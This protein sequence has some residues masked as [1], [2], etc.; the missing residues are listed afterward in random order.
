MA[1]VKK[2]IEEFVERIRSA[3]G[4]N[5][6]SVVLYGSAAREDFNEQY[7]DVNLLCLLKRVDSPALAQIAPVVQWWSG[8]LGRRPPLVITT[9]E[10]RN[11]AD[12]FAI[13][14]LDIKEAHRILHGPNVISDVDVPMNLHRVQLEHELRT[15]LLRLRQ[16]LL[17][18]PADDNGLEKVMA[19]SVSSVVV[20]FRHALVALGEHRELRKKHEIVSRV[21]EVL[22]VDTTAVQAALDL[23]EGRR[24]QRGV[25]ASYGKY[26]ECVSALVERINDAVPKNEWRRVKG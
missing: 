5:L 16:Q 25:A 6:Q 1:M 2:D 12:V 17:L 3:A 4:E 8:K 10:L 23:R 7:S 13:E 14:M 21:G 15:V 20:L 19:K 11:S 18:A 9:E 24:L 22:G 26:V